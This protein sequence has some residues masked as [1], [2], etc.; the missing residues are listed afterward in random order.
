MSYITKRHKWCNLYDVD[1]NLIKKAPQGK[2]TIEEVEKLL[3]ELTQKVKDNPDNKVYKVYLNN[4]YKTLMQMYQ[5]YG[6]PHEQELIR[7]IQ[8]Y[9]KEHG[10]IKPKET[11]KEEVVKALG[12]VEQEIE[13]DD[14]RES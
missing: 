1:G 4:T 5:T 3:N 2:W 6:N 12:E 10:E 13:Q 14:T 11:T 8:D 7:M 9:E